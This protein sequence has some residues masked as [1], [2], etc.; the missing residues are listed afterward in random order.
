MFE[1]RLCCLLQK[2][3]PGMEVQPFPEIGKQFVVKHVCTVMLTGSVCCKTCTYCYA[4]L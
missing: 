3:Q 1:G 4:S 2:V